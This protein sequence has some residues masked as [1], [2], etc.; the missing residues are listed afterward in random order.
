MK[1]RGRE[2]ETPAAH[3]LQH[4]HTAGGAQAASRQ[5]PGSFQAA[6]THPIRMAHMQ[7]PCSTA[8]AAPASTCTP[9]YR[10]L[11]LG[12]DMADKAGAHRVGQ[13]FC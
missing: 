13:R 3:T 10:L 6:S 5:L 4:R 2:G 8:S 7:A 9:A 1:Q 12:L 11:G